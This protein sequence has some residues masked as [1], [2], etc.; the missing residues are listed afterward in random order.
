MMGKSILVAEGA[1][2][3]SRRSAIGRWRSNMS[4]W[5]ISQQLKQLS[6]F[7]ITLHKVPPAGGLRHVSSEF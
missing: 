5:R 1:E 6:A 7:V 2:Y 3:I 4:H